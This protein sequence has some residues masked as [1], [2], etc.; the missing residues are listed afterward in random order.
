MKKLTLLLTILLFA[1]FGCE[2]LMKDENILV[3][4]PEL[5]AF[6]DGLN[7]DVGLSKS[8]TNALND[9]LNRHGK[10]GKHR[11]DPGFLWKVAAEMQSKL[12][13]DEKS[14]LFSWM[15]DNSVPYLYGGGMDRKDRGGPGGDKGG[16]NVRLIYELLD[17]AQRES[18][19][20]I[21]ETYGTK[22]RDLME[23][24]KAG[25]IDRDTAKAEIEALEAA[26]EAEIE[27]LLTDDQKQQLADIKAEMEN[28]MA[29]AKQAAHDAMVN[30]LEMTSEQETGLAEINT[31][32]QEAMNTLFEKAKAEEMEKD[33][34]H[35]A[36]KLL[37]A[38][39]N[40]KMD[41]LFNDKQMEIIKI[42]TALGMQYNRHCGQ[43]DRDG[44][45]GDNR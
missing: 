14:R 28:R 43:K 9:A 6:S 45:K 36:V 20:N 19:K 39:R 4:D 15:D 24:A 3:D 18:L 44:Q 26:M 35:E 27:G 2:K 13:D 25:T 12:S 11:R 40:S 1:T 16:S 17:E 5:Q 41:E 30:A 37:L 10:D 32:H 21:L 23:Q 34:L 8:S 29:E 33:D 7:A 31:A 38:D 22:M 42:Y